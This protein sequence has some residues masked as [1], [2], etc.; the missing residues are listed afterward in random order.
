MGRFP[1]RAQLAVC[2]T[3]VA[4]AVLCV[5]AARNDQSPRIHGIDGP[6]HAT[7]G[8]TIRCRIRWVHA[9]GDEM[10]SGKLSWSLIRR[11]TQE[12]LAEAPEGFDL[13]PRLTDSFCIEDVSIT[14]PAAPDP[15]GNLDGDF[16]IV[17]TYDPG[18]GEG[19]QLVP[20]HPVHIETR[21]HRGRAKGRYT[22][23]NC[24]LFAANAAP[25]PT[26]ADWLIQTGIRHAREDCS[27]SE[28]E[29]EDG[30]WN[31]EAFASEGRFGSLLIQ[32]RK[33]D[34]TALPMLSGIPEW[35]QTIDANGK[36]LGGWG[37]PAE[38]DR[39]A[40]FVD[41]VVG[42]FSQPPYLQ[43]Y[44]QVWNEAPAHP[45]WP[46]S[47]PLEDYVRKVH[48]PAAR[49]I[50]RHYVDLNRNGKKDVG[51][52]CR[53]VW[54]GWPSTHWQ[55]GLYA[56]ALRINDC[57]ALTDVLDA[58]YVQG[59][60]WYE[61]RAWSGDV[62]NTWVA[63]G[64]AIGC[65]QTEMGWS[66]AE[67]AA[68]LPRTFFQDIGWALAHNWNH[69]DKYRNYFFHYYAAQPSR[70]FY[71]NSPEPKWPNGYSIR[72]LMKLTRGDL[73]LPGPGRLIRGEN[74]TA[75]YADSVGHLNLRPILAGG[76]LLF[77]F[78]PHT[79]DADGT[80]RFEIA[81]KPSESPKSVARVTHVKG[82][83]TAVPFDL[84]DG[85]LH[86]VV[87]WAKT[88]PTE[89]EIDRPL[90]PYCYIVVEC[91]RLMTPWK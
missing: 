77:V 24:D 5:A 62:Y 64:S 63:K 39:W 2:S 71:W 34:M 56:K 11:S 48:L 13:A 83:E 20:A 7:W 12:A 70:G 32:A 27:W 41:R 6:P 31:D 81:L 14:L 9:V 82:T 54:G 36:S 19:V 60:R 29:P 73:A 88:A 1:S 69:K 40:A 18:A 84:R 38:A 22:P 61:R 79:W 35:A 87:P 86:F 16:D 23:R 85:L 30:R 50:R 25:V 15:L 75:H 52:R 21:D 42:H 44:W 78:W 4:L 65:W 47:V 37:P 28:F 43:Q 89:E 68:W 90:S 26:S 17:F 8:S 49:A 66:I 10:P 53:V 59:L 57:G 46:Q 72:T 51:E 45:F 33:Y 67:P 76:R 74:A 3:L 55:N 58:H 80:A 91:S